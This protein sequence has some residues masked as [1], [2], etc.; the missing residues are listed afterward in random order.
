MVLAL[1][2]VAATPASASVN[3]TFLTVDG[4]TNATV[5]EGDSVEAKVTHEITASTDAESMSWELVGSGL[6]QTCVNT[7]DR[8]A[9][10]TFTTSFDIDT[11]GASEGTWDVRIRAYGDDGADVSNLCQVADE[12]DSQLFS[13]RITVT[14][15]IDD[16][17]GNDNDS[18][19]NVGN[20]G[21]LSTILASLKVILDRLNT[22]PTTPAPSGKC[23]TLQTKMLGTQMN[24]YNQA[25][26]VLQGYLLGEGQSIPALAAGASFGYYGPQT[27]AALAQF[28]MANQ[29]I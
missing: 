1:S 22:T 4:A 20:E 10:G 18:N 6:P 23:A 7:V 17:Q 29:C 27:A 28:K 9:D 19:G 2:F 5:Q 15:D 3:L 12:V 14:D 21:T 16:N 25:N 13:D 26:V 11:S 24:V 8:I